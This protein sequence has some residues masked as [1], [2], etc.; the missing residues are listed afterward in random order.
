MRRGRGRR[1]G[2]G[3]GNAAIPPDP[4]EVPDHQDARRQGQAEDVPA[5][6]ADQGGRSGLGAAHQD[7][8]E[9]A[10]ISGMDLTRL[11]PATSAQR[12]PSSQRST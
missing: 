11:V 8:I 3:H 4:E 1:A 7:G 5:V 12:M 10:P 2:G 6:E 9:A